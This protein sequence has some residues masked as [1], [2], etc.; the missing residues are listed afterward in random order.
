MQNTEIERHVFHR[1]C[2][3]ILRMGVSIESQLDFFISNYFCSPQSYKTFLLIDLI[4]LNLN[5][6]RKKN[7][8]KLICKE[9]NI[10]QKHI[11]NILDAIEFVQTIR[12][13]IAHDE[14]FLDYQSEELKLQKRKS[15]IKKK[16]ELEISE[17]LVQKVND[18]TFFSIKEIRKIHM[19]LSDSNRKK[20]IEW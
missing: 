18:K 4:L 12:N 13:R 15:V 19:E 16:E 8:F 3:E 10:Q 5:F 14:T 7:I 6:E 2:G 17:E 20:N 11:S 9:E 1:N